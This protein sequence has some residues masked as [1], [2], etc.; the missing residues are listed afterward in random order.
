MPYS[1]ETKQ[2][3]LTEIKALAVHYPR[4]QLGQADLL[5]WYDDYATDLSNAGFDAMDVRLG[6]ALWRTS[7]AKKM[8]SPGELMVTCAKIVRP[9]KYR[10][11]PP[12]KREEPVY[13]EEH[14]AEMRRLLTGLAAEIAARA[15]DHRRKI[16]AREVPLDI[17]R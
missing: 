5:R 17:R 13:S 8:P 1:I 11:L 3:V 2:E 14:K 9:E 4:R 6:C 16:A 7:D 12:P 15:G 10:V